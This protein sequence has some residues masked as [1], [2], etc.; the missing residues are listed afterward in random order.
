MDVSPEYIKMCE[1]AE[2]IQQQIPMESNREPPN[3]YY[4]PDDDYLSCAYTVTKVFTNPVYW[5]PYQDQLQEMVNDKPLCFVLL[6]LLY[7]WS[8]TH[9]ADK[10]AKLYPSTM[11]QLWLAFVMKERFGKIWSGEEWKSMS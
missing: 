1:K 6:R 4:C 9:Y 5:L 10:A 2:E 8:F 7:N 11:E 3:L